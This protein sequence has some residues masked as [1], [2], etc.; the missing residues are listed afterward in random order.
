MMFEKMLFVGL[1]LL[2]VGSDVVDNYV[3]LFMHTRLECFP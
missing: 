2:G 3:R 1:L